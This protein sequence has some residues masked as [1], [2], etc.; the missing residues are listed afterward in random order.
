[1]TCSRASNDVGEEAVNPGSESLGVQAGWYADPNG[2]GQR[3]WD[4]HRWTEYVS[5]VRPLVLPGQEQ[6]GVHSHRVGAAATPA[7]FAPVVTHQPSTLIPST[8]TSPAARSA[9]PGWLTSNAVFQTI[10]ATAFGS[11]FAAWMAMGAS[12]AAATMGALALCV[13]LPVIGWFFG[14]PIVLAF[15]FFAATLWFVGVLA[16]A[17]A[18]ACTA[19]TIAAVSFGR[20]LLAVR[21]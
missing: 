6:A 19:A 5:T 15:A 20:R 11:V 9:A 4:G 21:R 2:H 12:L 7:L 13:A 8:R 3:Y 10:N 16:I 14:L 1:M 18:W 17:G